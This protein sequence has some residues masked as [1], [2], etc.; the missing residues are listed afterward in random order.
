MNLIL[1]SILSYLLNMILILVA[2]PAI[3]FVVGLAGQYLF[4]S[5]WL[6]HV[7][8]VAFIIFIYMGI[9]V[10][11]MGQ[12]TPL[13]NGE[14]KDSIQVLAARVNFPLAQIYVYNSEYF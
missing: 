1:A 10:P 2:I 3:I 6:L 14:L 5:L 7:I 8:F 12:I 4:I 11:K 9:M 13:E